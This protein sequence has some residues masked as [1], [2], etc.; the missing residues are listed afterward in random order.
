MSRVADLLHLL[1][2]RRQLC[3]GV[4]PVTM[5]WEATSKMTTCRFHH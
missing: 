1:V 3:L 4:R 5:D 2:T